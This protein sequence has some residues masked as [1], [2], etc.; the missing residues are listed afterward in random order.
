[1]W[2]INAQTLRLEYFQGQAIPDYAILS[3]TWDDEEVSFA[4]FNTPSDAVSAKKGYIK[5]RETCR[6]ALQNQL[7]YA[8]VDT[9][10]I[11]KSSSAELTESINSM[12]KWYGDAS[13]CF[14]FLHDLVPEDQCPFGKALA[15]CRWFTRGWTLQETIAPRDISFY[16][17]NW[18]L[19]GT[20]LGSCL[21]LDAI[22]GVPAYVLADPGNA[23]AHAVSTKMS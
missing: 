10:C 12:Y 3:H 9:C 22:T 2:L 21:A 5:I 6:L 18:E 7:G 8:W 11:D 20:K 14:A 16:D 15:S 17:G 13:T 4:D 23:M 1:M 19:R